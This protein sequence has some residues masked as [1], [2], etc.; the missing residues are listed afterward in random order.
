MQL[1]P[2]LSI[3]FGPWL[4]EAATRLHRNKLATALVNKIAR[5]AWSVLANWKAFDTNRNKVTAV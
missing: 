1:Q 2:A 3:S 5:I 4:T